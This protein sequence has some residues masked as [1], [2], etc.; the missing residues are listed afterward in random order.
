MR[1]LFLLLFVVNL[2]SIFTV[3]AQ[4]D[5]AQRGLV[6][7]PSGQEGIFVSWRLLASDSEDVGFN[8]YRSNEDEKD[9]KVNEKLI[10]EG[11]NFLDKN[12]DLSKKNLYYV[13]AVNPKQLSLKSVALVDDN[14]S[15]KAVAAA[16]TTAMTVNLRNGAEIHFAWIG[17]LDGDGDY[18]YII[19]RLDWSSGCKIEAYTNDG[20][21]L[22]DVDYGPNSSNMNNISPGSA[23]IDV[24]HWDGVTVADLNGD[25]QAEVITK[26]AD[27][28]RLGDGFVW[29]GGNAN[30]QWLVI[31]DGATGGW[32]ADAR[33]PD[34][35]ISAGPVA[36]QLGVGNGNEIF[37]HA[38]NRNSNG[39]FNIINACYTF[40]GS[41]NLK[42]QRNGGIAEGHQIRVVDVNEDGVDDMAHI[43]YV[44]N[45]SN[46]SILYRLDGIIHGDRFHIGKFDPNR[47]GLQ[48]YGVQ[49]DSWNNI[50]EYYYDASNGQILWTHAGGY[51]NGRGNAADIDPRYDGYE[52]WS[53]EG[54]FNGP[55]NTRITNEPDRPWPNFRIWWDGDNGSELYD[56]GDI[57]AWDYNN[58]WT[59]NLEKISD[60]GATGSYRGAPLFYG[61]FLGDWREEVILRNSSNNQLIILTT[62]I[63]TS[64]SRPSPME[65][66]YYRNDLT[67]KGYMQS[68]HTSYYIGEGGNTCDPTSITPY[69]QVNGG[70]W[71]EATSITVDEGD[72]VVFGPQPASGGSWSWSGCGTSGSSR[73]QTIYP[74]SSCVAVATYTNSCGTESTMEFNITVNNPAITI[75]EEEY[76]F[77]AVDGAVDN[78]HVGF[79]GSGFA[80]TDNATGNG[81]D[82]KVNFMSSGTKTFTIRY[83]SSSNRPA[84]LIV[85]GN[86]IASGIDFPSTGNWETWNEVTFTAYTG[87]GIS[88]LRLEATTSSGLGNIDYIEISD[89]Q[90]ADCNYINDG[91]FNGAYS[92]IAVHSGKALDTY[93]FGTVDGTNIAQWSYWGGEAQ[94]FNISQVDGI[95][96]RITPSIAS[97]QALDVSGVSTADGANIQTYS[98]WGGEGQQFRFQNEGAGQ[99]KVIARHSEKCID[100]DGGSTED[101]ANVL[102]W[103]CI[104]GAANQLFQVVGINSPHYDELLK[105]SI[106]SINPNPAKSGIFNVSIPFKIKDNL[107]INIYDAQGKLVYS[108]SN[109]EPLEKIEINSGLSKGLYLLHLAGATINEKTKLLIK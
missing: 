36:C 92:L 77:C 6:A 25:G 80:N 72:E 94:I 46:G 42:W 3:Q 88:D 37:M 109:L 55:T 19:D 107:N 61:D 69:V 62:T 99:W 1:K 7:V 2:V 85:N 35:Y 105:G 75:Q 89:A 59:V 65:D 38:K 56:N 40:N 73:E 97:D 17:D 49:Q 64:I 98:Y 39:S 23:T 78:N 76:G 96:H 33:I 29:N 91:I 103:S 102:Q 18:D 43:G 50:V 54:I 67:V 5:N 14:T 32:M 108:K 84:N 30:N 82:W 104:P 70:S 8:L 81:V 93:N 11:T 21:F 87:S 9:V 68:H 48:G 52:V 26:V 71:Q 13:D 4:T 53:F 12:A 60:Y 51:D 83:A 16:Q 15:P 66:R 63:P 106:I 28:V 90:A 47:P 10:T 86:V 24:G 20:D 31:L 44:L 101:G 41:L 22:W 74:T 79:T 27:G 45:G 100:V 34:D 58:N 95:W 57:E